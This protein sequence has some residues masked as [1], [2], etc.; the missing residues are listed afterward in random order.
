MSSGSHTEKRV[1]Q[2]DPVRFPLSKTRLIEASAGTG[3]TYQIANL[4]VRLVLGLDNVNKLP[5]PVEK[6][7][8]VTFTNAATDELRGRIRGKKI[9]HGS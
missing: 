5:L 8:V 6:I 2:L 7:L 4:Y 3:K 9:R 1:Q